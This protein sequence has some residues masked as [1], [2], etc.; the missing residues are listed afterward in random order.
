MHNIKQNLLA[1]LLSHKESFVPQFVELIEN[2][3]NFYDRTNLMG[4]I[5]S[6]SFVVNPQKDKML[7]V[8]HKKLQ[9]WLQPGGHID[10]VITPF[11]NAVKELQ[12]ECYNNEIIEYKVLE[13]NMIFDLDI[14]GV[15]DH[16][17]YDIGYLFEIDE[18]TPIFCSPES[19]S[20]AWVSID[21][22]LKN[23][24][25][26]NIRVQRVAQKVLAIHNQEVIDNIGNK[27]LKM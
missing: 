10:S 25:Y 26:D 15:G 5:T 27:P 6:S 9:C 19:D 18:C 12:E 4:H 14:H 1:D 7:L 16:K 23:P 21:D 8:K 24:E 22:I 2:Y 20:V 17:H 11:D 13:N 3:Q